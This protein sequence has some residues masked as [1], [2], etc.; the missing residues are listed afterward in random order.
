MTLNPRKD[1]EAMDPAADPSF[2]EGYEQWLAERA[3]REECFD[4][5]EWARQTLP[6]PVVPC[7]CGATRT[8]LRC[9]V[10]GFVDS[11]EGPPPPLAELEG[12][13]PF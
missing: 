1:L 4:L 12:P 5:L 2:W 13:A 9:R 3:A 6:A 7:L 8:C 11:L 10:A